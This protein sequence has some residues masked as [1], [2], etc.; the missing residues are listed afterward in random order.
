MAQPDKVRGRV[1]DAHSHI[2]A[3]QAWK[4]YDLKEPVKPTVYEF[5]D[6]RDYLR[7][8]D[9]VGVERGLVLPNYGIP[10]QDQAFS[11][12]PLVIDTVAANDRLVG[13]LWVSIL[14]QNKERTLETLKHAGEP[15][16]VALKTTFLLG[17]NP[18]PNTWDDDT[19]EL[20]EACFAAAERHDLVFHFHTSA[21]GASDINNFIP[22]VEQYGKRIK[23]YLVHFGG[24]VSGHIKL[25]PR[26]LDWVEQGYRVYCDTTWTIGFGAR[27]L[28]TE[29]EKRGVGADRVLFASD[30]PWSDF[31][32]EYWKIQGAP[33]SDELKQRILYRNY[34]ELYGS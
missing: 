19:R 2:G 12:N 31:W 3:M 1:V 16:I 4:F 17:G 25:V 26:F 9:G 21:G 34:E 32:G 6:G 29:I 24:G 28:M 23:I 22:L 15:G 7:H 8:L 5:A 27:W 33:V 20:A 18:D 13:G 10:V 30:E 14:P 11:L